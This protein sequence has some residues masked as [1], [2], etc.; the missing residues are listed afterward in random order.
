MRTLVYIILMSFL[1]ASCHTQNMFEDTTNSRIVKKVDSVFSYEQ[2]Y[3]YVIRKDDKINISVWG[4][5]ELSVGSI[6]GIYNS[7]EVYGKWLMVDARG[8]IEIP[9]IGTTYVL[10]K[11]IIEVKDSLKNQLKKWVLNPIVDVK[12]LNKEVTILGEVRNSGII[13]VDKDRNTLVEIISKSGGYEFYADL[14]NIKVFR[15][16]NENVYVTTIDLTTSQNYNH[17]N[18]SLHPGDVVVVPSKKYKVF[19]KRISTI[20][21]FTTA[22]SAAA[23]M[24]G[25]FK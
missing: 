1:L 4:Q 3:E 18:I 2:N 11:T 20:I 16:S 12:V 19:D 8:N 23:I 15:Q 6:Y 21:P 13:P 5:D 7:N 24:F 14:S 9:K 10:G 17:K 22:I 25:L